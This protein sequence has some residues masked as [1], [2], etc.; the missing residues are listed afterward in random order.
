MSAI[1]VER[2]SKRY[3]IGH[4]QRHD[5]FRDALRNRLTGAWFRLRS[6]PRTA[7]VRENF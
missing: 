1:I 3:V 7:I 6:A 5:T 4:Q 2:L